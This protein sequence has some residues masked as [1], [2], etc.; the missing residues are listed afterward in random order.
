MQEKNDKK[1]MDAQTIEELRA[2]LDLSGL[3]RHIA[4]IMDGNGRTS[5]GCGPQT[6]R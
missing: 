5:E 2:R 6:G 4:I 1:E 3:P